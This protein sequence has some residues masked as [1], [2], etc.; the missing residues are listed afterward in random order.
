MSE[1]SLLSSQRKKMATNTGRYN[2]WFDEPRDSKRYNM[3]MT[4]FFHNTEFCGIGKDEVGLFVVKNG[5]LNPQNKNISFLKRYRTHDVKYTGVLQS[6][7]TPLKAKGK[8]QLSDSPRVTGTWGMVLQGSPS[9]GALPHPEHP[10]RSKWEEWG[11]N[12]LQWV[13]LPFVATSWDGG[14]SL[15]YAL[16]GNAAKAKERL[17]DMGVDAAFDVLY[18]A[19]GGGSEL[20][21]GAEH[22]ALRG[23]EII[24][25]EA[26][27]ATSRRSSTATIDFN[28]LAD[29]EL[30]RTGMERTDRTKRFESVAVHGVEPP[31]RRTTRVTEVP[32]RGTLGVAETYGYLS[33]NRIPIAKKVEANHIPPFDTTVGTIYDI[34]KRELPAL[35]TE[36]ELHQ[37]MNR[38]F[39]TTAGSN[40]AKDLRLGIKEMLQT[41]DMPGALKA[42]ILVD[43]AFWHKIEFYE[44]GLRDLLDLHTRIRR[45]DGRPFLSISEY[46]EMNQWL[47]DQVNRFRE[48]RHQGKIVQYETEVFNDILDLISR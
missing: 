39:G 2:A 14:A 37:G 24:A 46:H 36:Y 29:T 30:E 44:K 1:L 47:T 23:G 5:V 4:L 42:Q 48:Y 19:T 9:H 10:T 16:T 26:E 32:P 31:S 6:W 38:T 33:N 22:E 8:W 21:L 27:E 7:K 28:P 18:L 17:C 13:P 35:T 45:S 12:I 40:E 3:S 34:G 11:H 15:F 25:R 20:V 43:Y 41:E